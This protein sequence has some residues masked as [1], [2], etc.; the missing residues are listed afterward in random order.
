M[1][2]IMLVLYDTQR[3]HRIEF[4]ETTINYKLLYKGVIYGLLRKGERYVIDITIIY[5]AVT[6]IPEG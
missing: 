6:W 4:I 1:R 2:P 3:S 5:D